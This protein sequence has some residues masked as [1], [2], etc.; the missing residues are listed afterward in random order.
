MQAT[1]CGPPNEPAD[2]GAGCGLPH[3]PTPLRQNNRR[4]ERRPPPTHL[5]HMPTP[6]RART[7]AAI[8]AARPQRTL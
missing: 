8:N 4:D 6:Q 2:Q 3:I 7:A 5:P 1:S